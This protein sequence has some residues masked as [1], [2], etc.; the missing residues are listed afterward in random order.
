MRRHYMDP[1]GERHEISKDEIESI[2]AQKNRSA[3]K[4]DFYDFDENEESLDRNIIYILFVHKQIAFIT[5]CATITFSV[6]STIYTFDFSFKNLVIC[7]S[8]SASLLS[9]STM[10]STFAFSLHGTPVQCA[11]LYLQ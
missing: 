6:C 1:D 4:P 7:H 8:V 3:K 9:H 10:M 5:I 11:L 2:L